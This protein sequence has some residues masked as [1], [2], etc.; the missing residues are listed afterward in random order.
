M[1]KNAFNEGK[2]PICLVR[3]VDGNVQDRLLF[4]AGQVQPILRDQLASLPKLTME[5]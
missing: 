3:S 4:Q 5:K 1:M 2:L